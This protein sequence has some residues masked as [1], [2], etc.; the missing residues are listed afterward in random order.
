MANL[1]RKIFEKPYDW[2]KNGHDITNQWKS[3]KVGDTV[4]FAMTVTEDIVY[5]IEHI[6]AD[7]AEASIR[8][9]SKDGSAAQAYRVGLVMLRPCS[10]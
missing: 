1:L 5:T 2:K 7:S 9:Q 4:E 6:Y 8:V 10:K 3:L